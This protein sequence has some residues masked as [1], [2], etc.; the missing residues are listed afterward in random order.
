[1]AEPIAAPGVG[2]G[3]LGS[4]QRA[5]RLVFTH[6]VITASRPREGA[7]ASVLAWADRIAI[8]VRE[9][10][11]YTLIATSKQVRLV[12][13]L[14]R[15]DATQHELFSTKAGRTF[16]RRR[17][18]YL[19]LMLSAFQRSRVEID[20]AG[21]VGALAPAANAIDGLGFDPIV[22]EHKHAVVDALDWLTA[23]GALRLSDGSADAW[24]RDTDRGNALYDIDHDICAGLFRPARSLQH[25]GGVLDLLEADQGANRAARRDAA[26]RRARRLLVEHPVVYYAAV[27][28]DTAAA[29]R[30]T[31]LLDNLVRLTG[32][33]VERRAEGV[34]LL[35]PSERFTDRHFPQRPGSVNRT[36]GL[37]LA[38]LADLLEGGGEADELVYMPVPLFSERTEVLAGVIDNARPRS[39]VAPE[40]SRPGRASNEREALGPAA[41]MQA[42]FVASAT[43]ATMVEELFEEL[44]ASTFTQLWQV[45][46]TGLR[47]AATV[48]LEEL[49]LVHR[50]PGGVLVLPAAARYRN[51]KAALPKRPKLDGQGVIDFT[52]LMGDE[53]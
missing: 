13:R 42:P 12:R 15:L 8:D 39:S 49:G 45:D 44:G 36:A 38:K 1:M 51:I 48:L 29:L 5:V 28:S 52:G 2:A 43:L 30:S 6:D 21:L 22:T 24:A 27:D 32:L 19:C 4:Y 37:L 3:D 20:L 9:L 18:A 23:R 46:P 11:G 50:V 47:E 14:D 7:L 17:L 34:M 31:E 25:I 10:F 26:A 16:D 53:E 41:P 40:I 35:D 33:T